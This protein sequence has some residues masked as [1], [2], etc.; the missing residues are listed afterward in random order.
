MLNPSNCPFFG[1]E[2]V[3]PAA[4]FAP[5]VVVCEAL[6]FREKALL[7]S[8]PPTAKLRPTPTPT[9]RD[10]FEGSENFR[11]VCTVLVGPKLA[12]CSVLIAG[13]C[14]LSITSIVDYNSATYAVFKTFVGGLWKTRGNDQTKNHT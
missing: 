6:D 10:K 9:G 3:E 7:R 4:P 8:A 1:V 2:Q 11:F 12:L 5:L 14:G 13:S